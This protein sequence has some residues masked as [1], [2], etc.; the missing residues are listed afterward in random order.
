MKSKSLIGGNGD[1]RLSKLI[2]ST[3][4]PKFENENNIDKEK[5]KIKNKMKQTSKIRVSRT[6]NA[7]YINLFDNNNNQENNHKTTSK[8]KKNT[9]HLISQNISQNSINLNDPNTFYSNYF[10]SIIEK[11]DKKTNE[12][13]V[14]QRLN[15]LKAFIQS[16]RPIN[17]N[18]NINNNNTEHPN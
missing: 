9:L 2:F 17:N 14:P 8:K 10:S 7:E 4:I 12:N 18:N 1:K 16:H 13:G 6:L 11:T 3:S 5:E 15:K